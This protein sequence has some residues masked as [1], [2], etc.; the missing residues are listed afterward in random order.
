MM[1]QKKQILVR[2]LCLL[3]N[4]SLSNYS[5]ISI[6]INNVRNTSAK[7]ILRLEP[8]F[9][10]PSQKEKNTD[11]YTYFC[12]VDD[13]KY[14]HFNAT[15]V[16]IINYTMRLYI[17]HFR[18]LLTKILKFIT[19]QISYTSFTAVKKILE[20]CIQLLVCKIKWKG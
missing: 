8:W 12:S 3:T 9:I 20:M 6:L 13:D 4:F 15:L 10:A 16:F 7:I 19:L 5:L 2:K 1:S 14:T 11:I 18:H 17:Y